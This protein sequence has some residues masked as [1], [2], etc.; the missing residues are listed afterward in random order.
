[1]CPSKR[2]TNVCRRLF[3]RTRHHHLSCQGLVI[4][5]HY[6]LLRLLSCECIEAIAELGMDRKLLVVEL[7]GLGGSGGGSSSMD[8]LSGVGGVLDPEPW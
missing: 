4:N 5:L 3:S 2:R 1:M 8:A 7:D 6:L